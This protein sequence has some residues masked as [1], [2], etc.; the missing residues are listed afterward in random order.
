MDTKDVKQVLP[1]IKLVSLAAISSVTMDK[2]YIEGNAYNV[3][4]N[5]TLLP[6]A[7]LCSFSVS[8]D[9]V[10]GQLI[11]TYQIEGLLFDL[12]GFALWGWN[13]IPVY[14]KVTDITGLCYLLGYKEKPYATCSIGLTVEDTASGKRCRPL[15]ISFKSPLPLH[16][17]R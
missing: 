2:S 11:Y 7:G 8:S 17:C 3:S 1:G 4:G 12:K 15:S 16:F 5:F 6:I 13:S 14:A 10:K 9:V